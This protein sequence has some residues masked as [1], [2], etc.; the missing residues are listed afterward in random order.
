M[1]RGFRKVYPPN[2][3]SL[4]DG[5]LNTKFE[6][7]I[8]EDQDSPDN[9]NV[10]FDAGSVGTRNGFVTVN[11]ASVGSFVCDGLYTR[12]GSNNAETMVAFY[13]GHG[14]TLDSTSLVT[15]GSA[16]SVFT[17]GFRVGAA[18]MEEHLFIGNGG[19]TPYKY[20]GVAFTRHGVPQPN[21]TASYVTGGAGNPNGAYSY[22]ILNRNSQTVAGNPSSQSTTITVAS[23]KIEITSIPVAPQSFGVATRRI[24]RTKTSGTTFFLATTLNDNTTTTFSDD[25]ADTDLGAE[26]PSDKG[27]PP[28]Y[29]TIIYHQNRLFM[30]DASQP[31]FV[32]FTDINEPFTVASTNFLI[33]GDTST[34]FVKGFGVQDNSLVVFCERNIWTIYMPSQTAS[35]WKVVRSRSSYSSKSPFGAFSYNNKLGFPAVQN[36]KFVG[37]AGLYGDSYDL[38]GTNLDIGTAASD[39]LSDKIEPDLFDVQSAYIG[40]ISSLVYKNKAYISVTKGIGNATNNR[41]YVMDFSIESLSKQGK[42]AWSRWSGLN[43]AQFTIYAGVLYFGSSTANGKLYK[44]NASVYADDSTAIDSYYWT[45]EFAGFSGEESYYKDFR[46]LNVLVDLPGSYFMNVGVRTDSD[47]GVGTMYQLS[48]DPGQSVWGTMVWG[49]DPWGGGSL[50]SDRRVYVGGAS[51]KRISFKFSNQNTINQKFKVHWLNYTYNLKGPR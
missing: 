40:N 51:G 9:L 16:Q 43:A 36:D 1:S 28:T 4:L 22:K 10:V 12:R 25:L 48:V 41:I 13:G 37:I 47:S 42:A 34:D 11:T 45:K 30:N 26:A 32:W 2:G 27:E 38:S 14:F 46:Y 35:D 3:K 39:L 6:A 5:G 19:V 49:S 31:G 24:Y 7:S 15:I 44:E 21:N 18:Q 17:A 33:I 50:Q 29:S 8:I 23:T 20:N